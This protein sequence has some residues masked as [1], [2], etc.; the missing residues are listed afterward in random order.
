MNTKNGYIYVR[1]NKIDDIY[2]ASNVGSTKNIPER[3]T[4]YITYEIT[5]G[6]FVE[7]YE[8]PFGQRRRQ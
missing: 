2:N 4:T 7:V 8:V 5:R 6:I 1:S 3:E